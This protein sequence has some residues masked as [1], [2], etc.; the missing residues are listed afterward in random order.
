MQKLVTHDANALSL[1]M[2]DDIYVVNEKEIQ[3]SIA[4]QTSL[5]EVKQE[6]V[7]E[8]HLVEFAYLGENNR[9]F[10][11][12]VDDSTHKELNS[13]HKEMLLKIMSAKGLELRDLAIVNLN[14]YP[15]AS[16]TDLKQF[17][18]CNR[19]ALFGIDPQRI[20]LPALKT[21]LPEKY[22]DVSI[23]ASFSLDEMSGSNDKKKLFWAV[24]KGF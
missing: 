21:N 17:F 9:Y 10:L 2:T 8:S 12:L 6:P 15:L 19:M 24:M 18:S 20:A 13:L 5:T 4:I 23:L 14:Q 3:A 1:F 11:V 7:E 22:L 16:F